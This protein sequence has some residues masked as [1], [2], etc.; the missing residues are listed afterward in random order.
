MY[1]SLPIPWRAIC[2]LWEKDLGVDDGIRPGR[3]RV[4]ERDGEQ[5]ATPELGVAKHVE[6]RLP[7][8]EKYRSDFNQL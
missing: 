2:H 6:K 4:V 3:R 1:P 8:F 7:H 5:T